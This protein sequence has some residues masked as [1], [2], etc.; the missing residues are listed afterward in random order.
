MKALVIEKPNQSNFHQRELPHC[1]AD[2]VVIKVAYAG[3]CGSDMHILHGDNPFVV[4]PRVSGHEFAGEVVETGEQV[5]HLAK[6]DQVVIDPVINCNECP[7]CRRGRA[8]CCINLQVIGVHRDG[9]F[10]HYQV[11]PAS[12]AYKVASHIPLRKAALIEPYTIAANVFERLNPS[13]GDS[14]LIYG[15]GVIGL[16]L[17]QVA[18]V[19][20]IPSIVVDLVDEKL[21]KATQLGASHVINASRQDV[22]QEVMKLTDGQGVPLIADAACIPSLLPQILKLA[23]PAGSVCLLGFSSEPS[24]LAQIEVIKKE[25]TIVGSRLNNKMFPRVISWLEEGKLNTEEIISHEFEFENFSEAFAQIEQRPEST[26]KA[27]I[28]F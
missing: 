27:L 28:C 22:E 23:A 19:L 8:N 25:L 3:I 24:A 2:E 10:C 11:V 26:M 18:K 12:N 1:G 20:N 6:G 15:S 13:S 14:I 21:A 4:Y 5:T 17:V 7:Q 16:T 9:G